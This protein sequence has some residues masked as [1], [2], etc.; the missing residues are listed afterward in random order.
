MPSPTADRSFFPEASGHIPGLTGRLDPNL[1]TLGRTY[2]YTSNIAINEG[3]QQPVYFLL[4]EDI[5]LTDADGREMLVRIVDITG[6][7]TLVEY[8][9][10][11]KA[12][13]VEPHHTP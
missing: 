13:L 5:S 10:V 4:G 9:L 11:S 6:R 12:V 1:D 7:S 2:L 3:R 8:R